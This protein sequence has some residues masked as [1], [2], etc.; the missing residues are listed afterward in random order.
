MWLLNAQLHKYSWHYRDSHKHVWAFQ[1]TITAAEIKQVL[2]E[3]S[4]AQM[5]TSDVF[6]QICPHVANSQ[7][8]RIMGMKQPA[9][10]WHKGT[11]DQS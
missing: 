2:A 7:V 11:L 3:L 8:K 4:Q 10:G 5:P 1:W 9:M 6:T